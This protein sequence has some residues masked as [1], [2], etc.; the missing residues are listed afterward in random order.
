[1]PQIINNI[2]HY[3]FDKIFVIEFWRKL[4]IAN[5]NNIYVTFSNKNYYILNN[6]IM[7]TWQIF[8]I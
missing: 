1:M 4:G 2:G 6:I 7:E 8:I 5:N 3:L